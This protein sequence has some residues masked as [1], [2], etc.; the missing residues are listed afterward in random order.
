[1][2]RPNNISLTKA[3]LL[4]ITNT[5]LLDNSISPMFD[6][7]YTSLIKKQITPNS[8]IYLK[9]ILGWL[10]FSNVWS[11]KIKINTLKT[12]VNTSDKEDHQRTMHKKFFNLSIRNMRN[13][14]QL[15]KSILM[16]LLMTTIYL[17][18]ISMIFNL[19]TKIKLWTLKKILFN[20]LKTTPLI[21]LTI[22]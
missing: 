6:F 7:S 13:W 4:T 14:H 18:K 11:I 2:I 22:I 5:T 3:I 15:K 12:L 9:I 16:I 10:F 21:I 8:H 1:M 19:V 17:V 20:L